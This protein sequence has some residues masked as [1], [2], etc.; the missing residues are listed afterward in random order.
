ML[1]CASVIVM[2]EGTDIVHQVT[3]MASFYAHESCGQ[4]TPCREGTAWVTNIL[5]KLENGQGKEEDLDTLIELTDQMTGT[6]ICVLSDSV[7][8]PVQ[9]SIRYFRED[10]LNLLNVE[11]EDG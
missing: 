2:D 11:A 8:A 7:A 3:R 1:G 4:C 10:Y 6:T 9:S 5:R